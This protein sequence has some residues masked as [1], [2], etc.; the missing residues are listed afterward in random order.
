M[1]NEHNH[2]H[3]HEHE[4]SHN[5]SHNHS[6]GHHHA[7]A[8]F[9]WA[10]AI[11]IALNTIFVILEAVYGILGHSLALL[12]DAG[13]NLSDVLGLVIAWIAIILVKRLPT[14]RRTFGLRGTSI[15]AAL[16]N[17][18]FLLISSGAIGWEA[19]QRF[20]NPSPVE[21]HTVIWVAAVGIAINLATAFL[22]M[23]GRKGDI[24][25][26]GAFLHMASDAAVALGV[27]IAGFAILWTGWLWLDP[28]ISILILIVILLGTWGLLKESTNLALAGVPE[29]ID[30]EKIEKYFKSL[31]HVTEVHD[32]HIWGISTTETALTVH[33]V[34]NDQTNQD[35]LLNQIDKELKGHFKI[36][37]PTIQIENGT[38]SCRLAPDDLV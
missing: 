29:G 37:H 31:P 21:G 13:H 28:A 5:H 26:R 34:I 35:N 20:R 12:A 23:S 10:Y 32:L 1:S 6:G 7:T 14:K 17:A 27:V 22:F 38:Y 30:V 33:L 15:L 25:I 11:G 16:F 19:I 9:G 24:N 8:N 4:H 3:E 36:D 18:V 2:E